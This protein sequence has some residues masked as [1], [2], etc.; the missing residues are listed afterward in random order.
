MSIVLNI[1]SLLIGVLINQHRDIET[2]R[3]DAA[4]NLTDLPIAV[5]AWIPR[6]KP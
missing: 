1:A 5:M 2:K 3:L 4:G 6:I